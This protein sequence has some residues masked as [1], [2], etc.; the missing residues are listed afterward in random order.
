[1]NPGAPGPTGAPASAVGATPPGAVQVVNATNR[2]ARTVGMHPHHVQGAGLP[3]IA[4]ARG[5]TPGAILRAAGVS[6]DD[7][8]R[9]GLHAP[10]YE[11][12]DDDWAHWVGC[13]CARPRYRANPVLGVLTMNGL[14]DDV[15]SAITGAFS[16]SDGSGAATDGGGTTDA[17]YDTTPNNDGSMVTTS[18]GPVVSAPSMSDGWPAAPAFRPGNWFFGT[19][20]NAT[21]TY[22]IATGDTLSGLA[23]LYLGDPSRWQKDIWDLQSY[24]WTLKPDPSSSNPGRGIQQGDVLVMPYEARDK[25]VSLMQ[26]MP[27]APPT[28]GAPGTK[29]GSQ[30]GLDPSAPSSASTFFA[31]HKTAIILGGLGVVVVGGLIYAN[32]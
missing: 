3:N 7:A 15:A 12:V 32:A 24:K 9:A 25:A 18:Q 10:Q 19:S 6:P 5:T 2:V 16:S 1:M 26:T 17:S 27:A 28:P 14:F 8:V 21:P 22:T 30:N 11:Y 20:S 23:R 29:P 31:Q 13:S 4:R